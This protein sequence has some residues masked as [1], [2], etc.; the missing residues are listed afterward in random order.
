MLTRT[1]WSEADI[2]IATSTI[3][4]GCYFDVKNHFDK[5]YVYAGASSKNFVRDIFQSTYR[6]RHLADNELVYFIDPKHNG[7]NQP[8]SK[9]AIEASHKAKQQLVE[10]Q[11]QVEMGFIH[12]YTTP[13]WLSE[14]ITYNTFEFNLGIMKLDELFLRYLKE[15]N[16]VHRDSGESNLIFVP[17]FEDFIPPSFE[18]KDIPEITSSQMKELRKK[19]ISEFLTPEENAMWEKFW[20]QQ[21]VLEL[22]TEVEQPL[23]E[24]YCDNNKGKFRNISIEKDWLTRRWKSRTWCGQAYTLG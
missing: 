5:V 14:L 22:P 4:V 23:W 18:Y 16:Y 7:F 11:H 6:V 9:Q 10:K 15:C 19:K 20:F 2:V 8:C 1:V 12:E 3:T 17:D 13:D 21:T 24:L